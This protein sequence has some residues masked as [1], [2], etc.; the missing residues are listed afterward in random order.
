MSET[1]NIHL[2]NKDADQNT[3]K[4]ESSLDKYEDNIKIDIEIN[5]L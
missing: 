3:S 5:S 1:P 4:G 2:A